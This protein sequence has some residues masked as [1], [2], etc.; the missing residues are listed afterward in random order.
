MHPRGQGDTDEGSAPNKL[1]GVKGEPKLR[2]GLRSFP[3]H[4]HRN[5]RPADEE[6]GRRAA[7]V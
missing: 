1:A 5:K 7:W 2:P 3:I 6:P 4:L